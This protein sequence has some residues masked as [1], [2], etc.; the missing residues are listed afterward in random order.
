AGG[1]A[2]ARP[3]YDAFRTSS[4]AASP[5]CCL[6]RRPRK[7][8]IASQ[9]RTNTALTIAKFRGE[10]ASQVVPANTS[11]ADATSPKRTKN[12]STA[13]FALYFASRLV[14]RNSAWRAVL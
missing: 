2:R 13:C 14:G 12:V 5:A 1:S 11:P 3:D 6:N 4:G 7:N 10:N 8:A 9:N